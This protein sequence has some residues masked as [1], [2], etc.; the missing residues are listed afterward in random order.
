MKKTTSIKTKKPDAENILIDSLL[1]KPHSAMLKRPKLQTARP[2]WDVYFMDIARLAAKRATCL[3]RRVGAV[4][5]KDRHLLSTGSNGAPKN[6]SHCQKTGC[7]RER[8]R[9]ASGQRHELCRGLHAE[10]NAIIQAALYGVGLRGATLY[11]TNMPCVICSK[12]IINAGIERVVLL[13]DY[14]DK[15]ASAFLREAGIK[16]SK[17]KKGSNK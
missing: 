11:C 8:L 13:D 12:M 2:S 4:I 7:L 9:I 17:V 3:R 10:Q 1:A 5:V 15:M 6:I 16:I 14:P